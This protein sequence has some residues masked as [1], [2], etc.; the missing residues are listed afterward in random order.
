MSLWRD[1]TSDFDVIGP[2]FTKDTTFSHHILCTLLMKSIH[3]LHIC[4]FEVV[5]VVH[6]GTSSNMT[7]IKEM[8]GAARKA[9]R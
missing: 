2:H 1:L 9:F 7:V 3:Q 8:R 5:A 6:D 4:G